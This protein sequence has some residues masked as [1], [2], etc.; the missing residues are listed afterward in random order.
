MNTKFARHVL[1]RTLFPVACVAWVTAGACSQSSS[2]SDQ[3]GDAGGSSGGNDNTGGNGNA[4]G[5]AGNSGGA[6]GA[7]GAGG[8]GGAVGAGG[9]A[10]GLL[11]TGGAMGGAASGGAA[12]GDAGRGG[13]NPSG[14]G[15][16]GG[17]VGTG[18]AG[19]WAN[20]TK[21]APPAWSG[22]VVAGAVTVSQSAVGRLTRGFV[23]LSYEKSHL[24]DQYF[25][26]SNAPLIAMFK[27]LGP[28][29]VRIGGTSLD[30]TG[31]QPSAPAAAPTAISTT[32]GTADVD[33][34]ASFLQA[35]K[36]TVLYGIN[37]KTATPQT[38]AA[39]AAYAAQKLGTSLA[40]F[41]IG[42]EPDLYGQGYATWSASWG[43]VA[44]AIQGMLPHAPLAGPATA[45]G[46]ISQAVQLAHDE[47][48]RLT[49]MTQHYY[50]GAG[51]TTNPTSVTMAGLISPDPSLITRLGQLS[52]GATSN[53]IPGGFRLG[54]LASFFSGG[55]P[56]VSNAYGSALWAID[57]LFDNAEHGSSGVNFHGGGAGQNGSEQ[58]YYS[59]ITEA[60][61]VV[62][63]VG[64]Q[65][66][67]MLLATSAGI[68]NVLATTAQAS[69]LNFTAH[70][71]LQADGSTN[72]ALNN[73]DATSAVR[74]TLTVAGKT[75]S[76]AS[77]VFL[78]G[79]S[80]LATSGVTFAGAAVT[81][82]GAWNPMPAWTLPMNG[83]AVMVVVP[84]VSAALVHIQ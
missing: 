69:N 2:P 24:T 63:G 70:S 76:A 16:A 60:G 18:G 77:V 1:V 44:T 51:K 19:L 17:S 68:G 72:V 10:G 43:A 8:A 15:G 40:A 7:G 41:E 30:H 49:I 25:S 81:V 31:W 5:G 61:G 52:A 84:P 22:P 37:L 27:L 33:A 54:E 39:E 35:T 73:K 83:N 78:Q 21:N 71:V 47:A 74:V 14:A 26:A 6:V 50:R 4:A 32:V 53:H 42:N 79:P 82:T 57:C 56:G 46:G 34:L 67:G 11:G 28:S 3:G 36:W 66:Y 13:G 45:G 12:A 23:G 75:A 9:A 38:D 62:T 20:V 48:S 80:L 59:P 55:A 65:F 64:P 58:F 29:N